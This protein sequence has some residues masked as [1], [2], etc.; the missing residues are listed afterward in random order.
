ME[1][2]EKLS[3]MLNGQ[4]HSETR[5]RFKSLRNGDTIKLLNG[6]G[7]M[8]GNPLC[9]YTS[10]MDLIRKQKKFEKMVFNIDQWSSIGFIRLYGYNWS[11]DMFELENHYTIEL[12]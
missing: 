9:S 1:Y 12:I 5:E 4:C 3:Q 7:L 6:K 2:E 8:R 10:D 11:L